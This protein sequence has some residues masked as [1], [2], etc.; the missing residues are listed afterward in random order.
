M[1]S[2]LRR[3]PTRCRW[4]A[5]TATL[6]AVLLL[7]A[8][9][10]AH[11]TTADRTARAGNEDGRGDADGA[12]G[13]GDDGPVTPATPVTGTVTDR[14]GQPVAGA[15]VNLLGPSGSGE[16]LLATTRSGSDGTFVLPAPPTGCH[17]ITTGPAAPT[18]AGPGPVEVCLG[19]GTGGQ[20]PQVPAPA[21][22][23]P[24]T[25]RLI[26]RAGAAVAGAPV[27]L[28][29][30]TG[31]GSTGSVLSQATTGPDGWY[32]F[33]VEPG[34][35]TVRSLAPAGTSFA[36]GAPLLD[37]LVCAEATSGEAEPEGREAPVE[38]G[39]GDGGDRS[40]EAVE[41]V[42]IVEL[43]VVVDDGMIERSATTP[44]PPPA[45]SA[46]E[47]ELVR[48]TNEL[49]AD[50]DGRLARQAPLPTYITDPYFA[51]ELDDATGVPSAV[52]ALV[53]DPTVSA[54]LSRP[55][56]GQMAAD[57]LLHHRPSDSQYDGYV[58]LGI[59]VD[60]W[61]ENIARAKDYDPTEVAWT[62][63]TGW[64]ESP[65]LH[66]CSLLTGRF[67]HLGVGEVLVGTS[68]WAAQNFYRPA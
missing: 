9:A 18:A 24:V 62:H 45:L 32:G 5:G 40:G 33:D 65:G 41:I 37:R 49:R 15:S 27:Q 30:V 35:Y 39:T 31:D 8:P 66:Y 2:P 50:P 13:G 51:I 6:V 52:P 68:S 21:A 54:G 10:P 63:F 46:V 61:G 60:S 25:G 64:R 17:R 67:T 34:C 29:A 47:R 3:P 42:E 20:E 57:G 56:A 7:A 44:A 12:V 11:G 48:L 38:V 28:L 58:S 1:I 36:N 16:Q 14:W 4:T 23:R 22:G 53:V 55:W 26:D 19:A 59:E 43:P